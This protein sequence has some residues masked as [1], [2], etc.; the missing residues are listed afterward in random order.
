MAWIILLLIGLGLIFAEF[1][2][3]GG[4]IGVLG[5]LFLIASIVIFA[6]DSGSP[7]LI[8]LY[9]LG[10]IFAV[11]LLIKYA[12]W[13]IPRTGADRSIYLSGDQEG[14]QASSFDSSMIGKTGVVVTDLKPGGHIFVEGKRLQALSESGYLPKGTEVIVIRGQEESLIV[15][16]KRKP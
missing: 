7:L 5:G 11:G 10:I 14:F 4:I 13:R 3:P 12:L 6:I 16:P 15:K 9:T 8:I 1:Y 2:L